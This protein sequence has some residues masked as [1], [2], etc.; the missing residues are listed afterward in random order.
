MSR[1]RIDVADLLSH[2]GARR[3]VRL[4]EPVEDLANSTAVV[5]DPVAV[6]LNLERISEGIVVR[7][8]VTATWQA[9]CSRCLGPLTR[10]VEVH[11]DELFEPDPIPDETYPIEGDEIDLDQLIRDTVLLELPLAPHC[12]PPCQVAGLDD[13]AEEGSPDPRWAALSELEL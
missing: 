7:G 10:P 2:A 8:A 5:V 13:A 3:Q 1:F 12:E 4:A 6:D 11:V 9:D